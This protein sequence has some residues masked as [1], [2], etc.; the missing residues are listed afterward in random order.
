[1]PKQQAVF[2]SFAA[3][4]ISPLL[5]GRPDITAY[6]NGARRLLNMIST[7]H[8]PAQRRVGSKLLAWD[9]ASLSRIIDAR[10]FPMSISKSL[11]IYVGV[12]LHEDGTTTISPFT[13]EG[14]LLGIDIER[15]RNGTFE[16]G[17]YL[18]SDN[19]LD[20]GDV[21]FQDGVATMIP[22]L[23]G[24]G[25]DTRASFTQQ[26]REL[27]PG[28]E[29]TMTVTLGQGD[30]PIQ[31]MASSVPGGGNWVNQQ[32]EGLTFS[33][34]FTPGSRNG[35]ITFRRA[36]GLEARDVEFVSIFKKGDVITRTNDDQL[37]EVVIDAPWA[38]E[39]LPVMQADS[40]PNTD[41]LYITSNN[42]ILQR[43]R[44]NIQDSSFTLIDAPFVGAP[45]EWEDGNYPQA[46]TFYQGRLWLGGP[47]KQ[48][49]TLWASKSGTIMDFT[50]GPDPDE[51]LE[52]TISEQGKIEWIQGA[53]NL[54]VGC[55]TGE[56]IVV[57]E[58]GVITPSDIEIT[59]QSAYG[60]D[61][62]QSEK[63]GQK[64]IYVS[65]DGRKLR[66][67]GYQWTDEGWIS[68][69]ISFA[70]EHITLDNSI[71]DLAFSQNPGNIMW[72]VTEPGKLVACT[73][74]KTYD[75]VGWH[76]HETYGDV[77]AVTSL[78]I[79][80][81]SVAAIAVMRTVNGIPR[82]CIEALPPYNPVHIDSWVYRANTVPTNQ[83][84]D[85][86]HLAGSYVDVISDGGLHPQ[87]YVDESGR[88]ELN[89][90]VSEAFIGHNF[91]SWMETLS[92]DNAQDIYGTHSMLKGWNR[93]YVRIVD[94]HEPI[95]NGQRPPERSPTTLND[96]PEQAFSGDVEVPDWGSSTMETVR[97]E[98][99]LPVPLTVVAVFGE[100]TQEHF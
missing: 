27:D 8:G 43:L 16:R 31:V 48:P 94:S 69:D 14:G 99:N 95:I 71:K 92:P 68:R 28:E 88:A 19:S 57:S 23:S 75:V 13:L 97:I 51:G 30:G 93:I 1:M 74:E 77:R 20:G 29:Y 70:S 59:Q 22:G 38:A 80:G 56:H 53:R 18:W 90:D 85:L 62:I 39:D 12:F 7:S 98:Q 46:I 37:F 58:E 82:M 54:V 87:V 89:R 11:G 72:C 84:A 32:V 65:P 52:F 10:L 36:S 66:E 17:G 78:D 55:A 60:S 9:S 86:G 42:V 47:P 24:T 3:G 6:K 44:Y 21:T 41:D 79:N 83:I 33:Q 35:Y 67:I 73:Y 100:I 4:E 45:T 61:T 26:I 49:E 15:V 50:Q 2:S 91:V 5:L 81:S 40:P 34:D 63:I 64:I 76:G 96:V 25:R